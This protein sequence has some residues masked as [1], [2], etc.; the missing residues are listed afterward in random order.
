MDG[1]S[2]GRYSRQRAEEKA[3]ARDDDVTYQYLRGLKPLM[4]INQNASSGQAVT[5]GRPKLNNEGCSGRGISITRH[6]SLR[7]DR[8]HGNYRV[9]SL[10]EGDE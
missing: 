8:Q 1:R 5:V 3:A 10:I 2:L 7:S 4:S 6:V 9:S